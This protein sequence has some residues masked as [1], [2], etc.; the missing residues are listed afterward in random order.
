MVVGTV[1]A[2]ILVTILVVA[3]EQ[4][5][6]GEGEVAGASYLAIAL[7]LTFAVCFYVSFDICVIAI[8]EADDPEDWINT[9]IH[10]YID[11]FKAMW[12][13]IVMGVSAIIA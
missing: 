4:E 9:A 12:M 2:L 8:P 1:I 7:G 11:I 3:V 10:V 13:M 5:T 6:K